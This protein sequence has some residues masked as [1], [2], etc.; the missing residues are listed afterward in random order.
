MSP[1][2]VA[3]IFKLVAPLLCC[4][5]AAC[6]AEP[7]TPSQTVQMESKID[8]DA[9]RPTTVGDDALDEAA[10]GVNRFGA[11]LFGALGDEDE[12]ATLS[13]VSVL[14]VLGM[15]QVGAA[16]DTGDEIVRLLHADD[17]AEPVGAWAELLRRLS[18]ESDGVQLT[19]GNAL[20]L[21]DGYAIKS[22][23]VDQVQTRFDAPAKP[24]DF[25]NAPGDAAETI[26]KWV[27]EATKDRIT[28]L[29][30]RDMITPQLRLI[31]T[32]AVYFKG[33]WAEQFDPEATQGAPFTLASGETVQVDMM[34]RMGRYAMQAGDDY[35]SLALPYAG[36]RFEMV[37]VLP[38]AGATVADV[39]PKLAEAVR[40]EERDGRRR[41]AE[42]VV[43]LPRFTF[44]KTLRLSRPLQDL[45]LRAAFDPSRADFSGISDEQ[46]VLSFVVQKTFIQVNEEGTEAAAATGGGVRATSMPPQFIVDRPFLFV[47]RE[48]SGG[49]WLFLGRVAKP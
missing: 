1:R 13:P 28:R 36:E 5:L 6:G 39:L 31:A 15:L 14:G 4:S 17:V 20:W 8:T 38:N 27:A 46:L 35:R 12:N 49:P 24:V 7:R 42:I 25:G 44:E 22:R 30:T 11:A 43:G 19:V 47:I 34:R 29:I 45:G 2:T 21:Q 23:Y 32:N 33:R 41:M 37:V 3:C 10:E 18:A 9:T 40:F 26:N 48:R 16:G